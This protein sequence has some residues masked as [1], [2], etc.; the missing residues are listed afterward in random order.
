MSATKNCPGR[1]QLELRRKKDG[2]WGVR[3]YK[4]KAVRSPAPKTSGSTKDCPG[5]PDY[6]LRRKKDGNWGT[7]C[8]KKKGV[9][10]RSSKV[11]RS[12]AVE[13]CLRVHELMPTRIHRT[14]STPRIKKYCQDF[15]KKHGNKKIPFPY[16]PQI[17]DEEVEEVMTVEDMLRHWVGWSWD[18]AK[19]YQ[20][21]KKS[22]YQR[23]LV[24]NLN[25]IFRLIPP[26]PEDI[27]LFRGIKPQKFREFKIEDIQTHY[28]AP[29]SWSFSYD[30][31]ESYGM[32]GF[33]LVTLLPKGSRLAVPVWY[34][35]GYEEE[36]ILPP[37]TLKP[38][39]GTQFQ[40]RDLGLIVPTLVYTV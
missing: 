27:I 22:A 25:Y 29:S 11:P 10:K 21:K 15:L 5:R 13:Q 34:C 18:I 23:K 8:Y 9:V 1:P 19:A 4:K 3:C 12:V 31:A 36:M 7:R 14:K 2:T 30:I 20:A 40:L 26:L 39:Q 32:S 37:I 28:N 24:K 17:L 38:C 16:T 35:Q 6:E 33:V